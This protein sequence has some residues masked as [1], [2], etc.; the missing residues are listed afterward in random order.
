MR[1]LLTLMIFSLFL[2]TLVSAAPPQAAQPEYGLDIRTGVADNIKLNDDFDFHAHVFNSSN[3]VPIY[4]DVSCYLH[5]YNVSGKHLYEGVDNVVSHTYDYGW[6]VDGG[7]FSQVGQHEYIIQCNN[8]IS[9]GFYAGNFKVTETGGVEEAGIV[10]VFLMI[11]GLVT[12]FFLLYTLLNTLGD[13]AK[14]EVDIKTISWAMA[15][16]FANLA[17]YYYLTMFMPMELMLEISFMGMSAFGV[18]HIFLPL[19]GLIFSWIKNREVS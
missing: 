10:V 7:N 15:A 16:Y 8:S 18:T 17:Y 6:D 4:T 19:V 5:I 13:F 14:M 2:F 11:F 3:G 12:L 9:G 1:K